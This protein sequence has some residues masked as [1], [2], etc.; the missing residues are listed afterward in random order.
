MKLIVITGQTATGKTALALNYTK[1]YHG[2]LINADSRQVYKYL[3]I[4]AGKDLDLIK[5]VPIHLY[6]IINPKEYYSSY[7][8]V[9]DARSAIKNLYLRGKTPIIVGGT[10]FYI[11]HLLYGIGTEGMLV[12]WNLRNS[13]A[14]ASVSQ[15]Q[16]RLKKLDSKLYLGLNDSEKN[17]PQR[18]VRKIEIA[19]S[20]SPKSMRFKKSD[21]VLNPIKFSPFSELE[22]KYLGLRFS[23]KDSMKRVIVKRVE[24]RIKGGAIDEVKKLLRRGYSISDP[25]LQAN[26]CLEISQFI[27][28]ELTMDELISKWTTIEMRYAKRQ[29]TFMK[30]DPNIRWKNVT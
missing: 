3:D 17:N 16:K 1:K 2:E 11:K 7:N 6:S 27:G 18:L 14:K 20:E 5:K 10:Y 22:I 29:Y 4:V 30:L 23:D 13:L 19:K 8:F 24:Q 26:A 15:L 12:D 9:N 21:F 25:G 28:G